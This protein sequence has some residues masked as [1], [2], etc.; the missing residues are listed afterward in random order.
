MR[1]TLFLLNFVISRLSGLTIGPFVSG[2]STLQPYRYTT[3]AISCDS[4]QSSKL[5]G[6]SMIKSLR[7]RAVSLMQGS[8]DWRMNG[9]TDRKGVADYVGVDQER[10]AVGIRVVIWISDTGCR[11]NQIKCFESKK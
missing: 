10:A 2:H 7:S 6:L 4:V 5:Y 1:L 11:I 9:L 3:S 8:R